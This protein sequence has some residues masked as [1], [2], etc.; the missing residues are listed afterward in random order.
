[1]RNKKECK[2]PVWKEEMK[3]ERKPQRERKGIKHD[4]SAQCR[5]EEIQAAQCKTRGGRK[6]SLSSM[7]QRRRQGKSCVRKREGIRFRLY[8]CPTVVAAGCFAH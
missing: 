7:A 1:M 4:N 2:P 8:V 6:A 5:K 3:E